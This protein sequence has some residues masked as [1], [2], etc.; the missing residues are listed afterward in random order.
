MIRVLAILLLGVFSFSVSGQS[1]VEALLRDAKTFNESY[2]K[3]D[4]GTYVK[5][6]IPSVVEIA[7]G[8]EVMETNVKDM[9]ELT[10]GGGVTIE[11]TTPTKPGKIMI[12]G[13]ELH[14]LLPQKMIN[15]IGK[16]KFS[17]VAYFLASSSDDGK[18][19]TFLD[20]EPYD[21]E[22]IKIFVPSFTGEI[23]IPEVAQ[24]ELIED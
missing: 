3:K 21:A 9:Y 19:W 4:F 14:S 2:M 6:M 13:D 23:D 24:P 22:S 15:K 5:M 12:A 10:L 16:T 17:K 7:G 11:S 1:Q 8:A 20:L 18:T